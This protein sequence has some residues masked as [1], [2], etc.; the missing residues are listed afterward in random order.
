MQLI[1]N[2]LRTEVLLYFIQCIRQFP[3]TKAYVSPN[4]DKI[5]KPCC[6]PMELGM[7]ELLETLLRDLRDQRRGM[8]FST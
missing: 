8:L 4:N 5:E 6:K 7:N 3:T 1:L 2:G